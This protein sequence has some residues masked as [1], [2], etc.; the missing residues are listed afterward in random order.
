MAVL[1]SGRP[2]KC[3]ENINIYIKTSVYTSFNVYSSRKLARR[4]RHRLRAGGLEANVKCLVQATESES[5]RTKPISI[6]QV[7]DIQQKLECSRRLV[8]QPLECMHP[9]EWQLLTLED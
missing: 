1:M 7:L 9:A 4:K 5:W 8:L 3:R 2:T 6:G